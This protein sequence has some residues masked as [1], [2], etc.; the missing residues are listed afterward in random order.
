MADDLLWIFRV[1]DD[2]SCIHYLDDF[3]LCGAPD[4][5]QCNYPLGKALARCTHLGIPVAPDKTAGPTAVLVFLDIQLNTKT[6]TMSLPSTHERLR[7]MIQIWMSKKS[8]SNVIKPGREFLRRMIDLSK[9]VKELH[10]KVH[11]NAGF[12]SDLR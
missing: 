1:Q 4:S 11:L 6:L 3:L 9:M 2:V 10:H 7:A 8:C 12:C 5:Q